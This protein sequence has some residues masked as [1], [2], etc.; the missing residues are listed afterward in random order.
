M[1]LKN[2]AR[3]RDFFFVEVDDVLLPHAAQLDPSHAEFAR[4][5]FAGV[6]E[7]LRYLIVDDR[8]AEGRSGIAWRAKTGC[9]LRRRQGNHSGEKFAA[10]KLNGHD[11]STPSV[12]G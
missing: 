8:N 12:M 7:V 1:L 2:S 9:G 6:P 5:D 10:G 11:S 3:F 4:R